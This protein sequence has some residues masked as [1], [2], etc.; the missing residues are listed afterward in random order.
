MSGTTSYEPI[1]TPAVLEP[2]PLPSGT[3]AQDVA[4]LQA[5]WQA[6]SSEIVDATLAQGKA[7]ETAT[8]EFASWMLG[9]HGSVAGTLTTLANQLGVT[10]PS[11]FTAAQSSQFAQLASL[12]GATFDQNYS[13]DEVADHQQTLALFE[14]EAAKGENPALVAFAKQLIPTLEA[15]LQGAATLVT[16]TTGI[17]LSVPAP[18]SPT[19]LASTGSALGTPSAQDIAFVQTAALANMA[20]VAQGQL[21]ESKSG[22]AAGTEFAQWMVS[23]H[24]GAEASLQTLAAQ[25]GVAL[26]TSLDQAD[27]QELGALQPLSGD[28]F[29]APYVTG[30]ILAHTQSLTAFIQEAQDGQDSAIKA[31]AETGI[32]VL[33]G[34]LAGA[35]TLA[36][37]T[38][39]AEA[40]ATQ[41]DSA[42]TGLLNGV[43]A[44]GNSQ[45][46]SEMTKIADIQ[47]GFTYTPTTATAAMT[48]GL[49]SSATAMTMAAS[50]H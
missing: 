16:D 10:L 3:N 48:S 20:E 17:S 46:L 21:A 31:Y 25:E 34:H 37:S 35:L 36:Q 40:A 47:P 1:S 44:T 45:L 12:S 42:L 32:P 39:G 49:P 38:P 14:T 43:A 9:D 50:S 22:N 8:R 7:T 15:H 18:S 26:P 29:F 4:F 19:P 24:S 5:A 30:Q 28:S 41:I 11:S 23:D 2:T 13:I 27:Q 33:A 6:N